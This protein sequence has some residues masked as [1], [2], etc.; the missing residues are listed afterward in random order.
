MADE[1][2]TTLFAAHPID[3]D[4]ADLAYAVQHTGT[5]PLEGAF[6]YS[7]L[8][9]NRYKLVPVLV[10]NNLQL[11]LRHSDG[12]DPSVNRPLYFKIGDSI[13]AITAALNVVKNAG[14]SWANLGS[15]ELATKEADLF[16]YVVWNTAL[17][18]PA[19]DIFW[20]RIP[21]GRLYS[22]FSGTTTN[23]KYAAVNATPPNAT[24]VCV[25]IGRFAATLSAGGGYTW[26]VPT[27]TAVNLINRP[28]YES[29]W[30]TWNNVTTCSGSLTYGTITNSWV[31]YKIIYGVVFFSLRQTGT[32]GGT[33]STAILNTLPFISLHAATANVGG[34]FGNINAGGTVTALISIVNGTPNTLNVLKYD[35]SNLPN[36][37][38]CVITA[39][40]FYEI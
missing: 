32:L 2:L 27:F 40:G 24:D 13:C 15:A 16:A 19:V 17:G 34:G 9:F 11:S 1:K 10:G 26:T 37:G 23:E 7:E 29:R 30:L 12:N 6:K 28:I 21:N 39:K 38:S 8:M 25:N 33:A 31:L 20:S 14:T 5:T 35:S 4:P 18:T 3:V 36:S 22:D